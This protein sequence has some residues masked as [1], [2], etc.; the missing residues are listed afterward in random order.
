MVLKSV[1]D[2]SKEI[3]LARDRL[4]VNPQISAIT[5]LSTSPAL[6]A[7]PESSRRKVVESWGGGR[8]GVKTKIEL[9]DGGGG[10]VGGGDFSF[11]VIPYRLSLPY[12]PLGSLRTW[13]FVHHTVLIDQRGLLFFYAKC[14]TQFTTSIDGL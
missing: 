4:Q 11:C 13:K 9:E 7:L 10:G 5:F 6:A 14:I 3:I 1:W 12:T 8:A 2:E